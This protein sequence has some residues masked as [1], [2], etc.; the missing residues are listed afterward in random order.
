[1]LY[2]LHTHTGAFSWVSKMMSSGEDP[3]PIV[4]SLIA[5]DAV[6]PDDLDD[7]TLWKI[8]INILSE[9]DKRKKLPDINTLDQVVNLIH[10]CQK[11]MILTGA[12]VWKRDDNIN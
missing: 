11:I 3:R 6:I 12:G 1:M 2:D 8:I 7:L 10:K 5:G 4:N 9:P